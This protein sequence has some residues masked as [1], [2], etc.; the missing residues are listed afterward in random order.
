VVLPWAKLQKHERFGGL[1][2]IYVTQ[3]GQARLLK[4]DER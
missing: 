2:H 1:E 3:S 4:M